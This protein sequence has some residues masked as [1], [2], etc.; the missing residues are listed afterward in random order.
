MGVLPGWLVTTAT[1]V[2][3][4]SPGGAPSLMGLHPELSYS[5]AIASA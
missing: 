4:S 1:Q 5:P 2:A 3:G